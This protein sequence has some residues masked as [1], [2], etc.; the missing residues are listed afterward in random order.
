MRDLWL[1]AAMAQPPTICGRRLLPFSIAHEYL[2]KALDS[3]YI[4]GGRVQ[5][6]DVLLA[7]DVCSRSWAENAA[8]LFGAIPPAAGWRAWARR[9]RRLDIADRSLRRYM[10]D[11]SASPEHW[12]AGPGEELR[13]P[14]EWH[15]VRVLMEHYGFS[16]ASAWDCHLARARCYADIWSEAQGDRSLVSPSEQA[17]IDA[18]HKEDAN[19]G[20]G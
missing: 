2:L 19:G 20:A 7:V 11:F 18:A 12:D 17:A 3:P 5:R 6:A 16:E 14:W 1:Q 4:V 10:Q 13:G 8:R 9:W 15:L